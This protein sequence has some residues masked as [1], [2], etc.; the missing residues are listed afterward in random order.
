M[1]GLGTSAKVELAKD[2][3]ALKSSADDT[4]SDALD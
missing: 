4:D 2:L 3:G 1:G